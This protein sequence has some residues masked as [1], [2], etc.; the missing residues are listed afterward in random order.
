MTIQ[1]K[2]GNL[3]REQ[4]YI[5]GQWASGKETLE[6]V[7]PATGEVLAKV[8]NMGA[9][10]TERAIAAAQAAL[11]A[12]RGMLASERGK[13]LRKWADLQREHLDDL[14]KIL[15]AEQGKPLGQARAEIESGIGYVEWM[16][17]EGRR[18]YGDL[19]PT[20]NASHR[21]LTMK[22][23]V[24]VCAMVTP[25]NFPSSMITRKCGPALAAGCTVVI[26]PSELTPLSAFALAEL[27]E[28]AGIPKGVVNILTGDAKA[29]GA[30]MT[31]SDIVR[32]FSFTGST[33]VGKLLMKQCADT[34]KKI[35]LEL[36]G[37]APFIV[38]DDADL[39]KAVEAAIASKF[40]NAGQTCIC[41]NRIFVQDGIYDA[42]AEK[43][44]AA[45]KAMSVGN[46]LEREV[47]IGP[48][49]D[50]RGMKKVEE[51]LQD[52]VAKGGRVAAG[53][54]RHELG[55]S[56]FQP[57]VVTDA[58]RDMKCFSEET[59]G[60][61]APLFR[62]KDEAEVIGLA[63]ATEYGL[64]AYFYARDMARVFRVAEALEYG[65][66][67]VNS[68]AIVAPQAPF[69]GWK[70]SGMGHEGSKYGIEDYLELKLVALGGLWVCP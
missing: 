17:E 1:L 20:H 18:V 57:T 9:A 36:G 10:E 38:F 50:E 64:A 60:P 33:A 21:L 2:D 52:A 15:T 58:T 14:C 27:A 42:F 31:K 4:A 26:K 30:A 3:W 39:D 44:T 49:I 37:N 16:A 40:R 47:D 45:V 13:I 41:A 7:N 29:I 55:H 24:G 48:M 34:V 5:D 51:H 70:Q 53:G 43:F 19:I 68:A 62:F 23:P 25:W 32:K 46:A 8:P 66:V 63:N 6:V 65:M 12:W 67:G 35:S 11:P 69:G 22:Q 61:F 54:K 56:F 28:R 59:F